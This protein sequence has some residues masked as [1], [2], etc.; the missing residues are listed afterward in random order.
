MIVDA[1]YF[2]TGA[3]VNAVLKAESPLAIT[4][5]YDAI[6]NRFFSNVDVSKLVSFPA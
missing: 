6:K 3:S 1:F 4:A 5:G 2:K